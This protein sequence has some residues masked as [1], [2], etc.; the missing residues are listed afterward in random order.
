[1]KQIHLDRIV[2]RT[3]QKHLVVVI[4]V[5]ADFGLVLD[6]IHVLKSRRLE[7]QQRSHGLFGFRISVLP[8]RL[9]GVESG[10]DSLTI[11]IAVLDDDAFNRRRILTRDSKSNWGTIVLNVDAEPFQ[12]K[13]S[14][15][16]FL[17][18][19]REI[20]EGVVKLLHRRH[21]AVA[22]ADIIGG[23][24]VELV[25]QHRDQIAVHV[26][27]AWKSMEQHNDRRVLRPSLTIED[28]SSPDVCRLVRCHVQ[29]PN[30]ILVIVPGYS[31]WF[32]FSRS[33]I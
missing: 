2:A 13:V 24:K 6:A 30:R 23:D 21:V 4:G 12:P 31:P 22:E 18:M 28:L 11:S 16:Q 1:V 9:H 7:L 27:R 20:V 10:T 14:K 8:Q 5:R 29:S 3:I 25:S 33:S 15:K 17:H 26:R 19:R 32:V